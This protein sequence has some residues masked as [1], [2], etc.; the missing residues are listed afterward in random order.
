MRSNVLVLVVPVAAFCISAFA[1]QV[2]LAADEIVPG[3]E[4]PSSLP[5]S[6]SIGDVFT[7]DREQHR[8][9]GGP[10][11]LSIGPFWPSA[12][13]ARYRGGASQFSAGF[14]YYL[15]ASTSASS[16]SSGCPARTVIDTGVEIGAEVG[17][18]HNS[19]ESIIPITIG[20]EFGFNHQ[21]PLASATAYMGA[22]IGAYIMNQSGLSAA[23]RFGGFVN[24]GYN[25]A[26]PVFVEARYQF[27]ENADG[28]T[29]NVGY[30]F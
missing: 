11:S 4:G 8:A 21:S 7:L 26:R 20:E 24:V 23:T 22:G 10:A 13:E 17:A 29:L 19:H 9:V 30:R 16:D 2:A 25:F 5:S 14:R 12:G 27:V 18:N 1:P 28:A 15:P 6:L 3:L